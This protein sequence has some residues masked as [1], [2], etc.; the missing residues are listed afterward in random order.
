MKDNSDLVGQ[1]FKSGTGATE[2]KVTG[3]SVT[4][5]YVDLQRID[6]GKNTLANCYP[7]SLV[8]SRLANE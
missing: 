5:G 7:A 4:P 6:D 8:R 3:V 1:T 2:W